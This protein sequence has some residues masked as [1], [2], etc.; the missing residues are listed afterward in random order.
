MMVCEYFAGR[1]YKRPLHNASAGSALLLEELHRCL[2]TRTRWRYTDRL[3]AE[4]P[5]VV[6]S[7]RGIELQG[8][9]VPTVV[10]AC[11]EY[12]VDVLFVGS[13]GGGRLWRL[14]F[15]N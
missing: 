13:N 14:L 6:W 3:R 8:Y 5:Q 1:S 7:S 12:G 4:Y 9:V 2:S 15:S 10:A 11:R